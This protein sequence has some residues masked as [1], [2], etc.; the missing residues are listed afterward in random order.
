VICTR[1][2]K[3]AVRPGFRL[4]IASRVAILRTVGIELSEI[5]KS[6]NEG[7]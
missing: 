3:V 5:D 1:M 2:A 6:I 7:A 4:G